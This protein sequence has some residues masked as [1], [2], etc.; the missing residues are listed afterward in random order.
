MG[1]FFFQEVERVEI[2]YLTNYERIPQTVS[3]SINGSL[4]K[5]YSKGF[6]QFGELATIDS[7]AKT[8]P[9]YTHDDI[10][11]LDLGFVHSLLLLN[12]QQAYT[13]EATMDAH[14]ELMKQTSPKK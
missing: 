14:R 1:G 7:L 4:S 9:Q 8:Y 12:K 10:T 5:K 11:L 6:E 3:Q 2:Q 13:Q